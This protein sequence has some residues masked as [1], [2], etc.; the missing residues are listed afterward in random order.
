MANRITQLESLIP[1][2]AESYYSGQSEV[3]DEYFD[4]LVDELRSLNPESPVLKKTGWGFNPS[5]SKKVSHLYGMHVG[6]LSKVKSVEEI[7]ERLIPSDVG[8]FCRV[9]AKMDGLSVVSYYSAGKR[10]LAVTRGNGEVGKDVTQKMRIIDPATNELT[11]GF[12]GAVRGEVL[13]DNRTW[14]RIKVRY[15]DNPSANQRNVAAGIMNRNDVEGQTDEDLKLLR[16]VVYKV[17]ACE[18]CAYEGI[19]D[20]PKLPSTSFDEAPS[21][22]FNYG[23]WIT[24]DTQFE[25]LLKE[26]REEFPCD[27]LVLTKNSCTQTDS[28]EIVYDEVAYKFQAESKQV[29]VKEVTW[30][31]TRTGRIV[32]VVWFDPVSLSG[33][34]V[35]KATGFNA[36]FIL[37]NKIKSGVKIVV[38]RSGEVIPHIMKVLDNC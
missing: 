32:P 13:I 15:E 36:K 16:Y 35:Q 28:G 25:V 31:A 26:F 4:A 6:S 7:P 1:M 29:V 33:A 19:F 24:V 14:D 2:Y 30:S 37:D 38:T 21:V 18:N 12:T 34:M 10:I 17:V 23:R 11:Y 22:R 9:S 27:G 20:I 3:S 8:E 5:G